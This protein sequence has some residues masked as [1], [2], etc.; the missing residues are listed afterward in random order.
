MSWE[1]FRA[2]FFS[3]HVWTPATSFPRESACAT[4]SPCGFVYGWTYRWAFIAA[5]DSGRWRRFR[6]ARQR[7]KG[8]VLRAARALAISFCLAYLY[9]GKGTIDLKVGGAPPSACQLECW[10]R[11]S[12]VVD[13][14]ITAGSGKLCAVEDWE[15][16]VST[17]KV[18]YNG[19]ETSTACWSTAAQVLPILPPEGFAGSVDPLYIAGGPTRGLLE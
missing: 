19:Q 12:D 16:W 1:T 2:D 6:G 4:C 14:F 7:H 15:H 11:I 13:D 17:T 10:E 5:V 18:T 3:K 9:S 8:V